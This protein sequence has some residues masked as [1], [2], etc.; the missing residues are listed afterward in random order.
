LASGF[1]YPLIVVR[2]IPLAASEI[3]YVNIIK[4]QYLI[5]TVV[6]QAR[7]ICFCSMYTRNLPSW[8]DCRA[9]VEFLC[10][11]TGASLKS[12]H[13]IGFSLGAHV[14]GGA[15]AAIGSGKV[16]RIT[17]KSANA[18]NGNSRQVTTLEG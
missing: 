12:F 17:G 3:G 1:D 11:N 16:F 14:A 9:F 15:G 10:E 2:N 4:T 18:H 13:L 7:T 5:S 8:S 6:K